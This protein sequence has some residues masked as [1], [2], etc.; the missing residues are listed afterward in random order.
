YI[1]DC[2]VRQ[3]DPWHMHVDREL[4]VDSEL[5]NIRYLVT[6]ELHLLHLT[7]VTRPVTHLLRIVDV[8]QEMHLDLYY[9]VALARL[10]SPALDVEAEPPRLVAAHLG[11]GQAREQL[12]HVGEHPR[13][14]RRVRSRRATDRR[15]VDVDSF[16]EILET[17]DLPV[18]SWVV[19]GPVAVLRHLLAQDVRHQRRLAGSAHARHRHKRA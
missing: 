4:R 19:L 16:I 7:L 15:L 12:P 3:L 2:T 5:E 8:G 6:A 1:V 18:W 11:F 17:L 10:A 9:P 14:R 13:V